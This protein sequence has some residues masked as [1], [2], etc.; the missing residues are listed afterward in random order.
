MMR[1]ARCAQLCGPDDSCAAAIYWN[2]VEMSR[3]RFGSS[4]QMPQLFRGCG[5]KWL[6]G[7]SYGYPTKDYWR[8]LDGT[9]LYIQQRFRT[10]N[11][12]YLGRTPYYRPCPHCRSLDATQ[13]ESPDPS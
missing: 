9:T 4:A 13:A 1:G 6:T 8:G 2:D 11:M 3:P 5:I 10:Q 12:K 7:L